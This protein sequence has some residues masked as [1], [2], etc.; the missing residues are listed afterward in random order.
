MPIISYIVTTVL[1]VTRGIILLKT[2]VCVSGFENVASCVSQKVNLS[3]S[4]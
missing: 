3:Y 1:H 2:N 4:V